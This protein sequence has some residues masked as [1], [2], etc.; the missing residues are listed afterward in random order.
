MTPAEIMTAVAGLAAVILSGSLIGAIVSWRRDNRQ[1]PIERQQAEEATVK[2]QS[3]IR[4][5]DIDGL[6]DI[7]ETL[8]EEVAT[9]RS[10]VEGLESE[11]WI[12]RTYIRDLHA[13]HPGWP[14]WR[15]AWVAALYAPDGTPTFPPTP[16]SII[17]P[18]RP[19]ER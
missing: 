9:L 6:R 4:T 2:L 5:A 8:R 17:E 11:R 14:N 19:K 1:A 13:A 16:T 18:P 12:D 10:H 7:I 3:E 15:P